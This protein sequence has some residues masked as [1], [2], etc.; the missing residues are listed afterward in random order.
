MILWF[1]FLVLKE[2]VFNNDKMM[3]E[4]GRYYMLDIRPI[5]DLRNKFHEV[6]KAA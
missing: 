3:I 6:E 2:L 1:E 4:Y 5:S